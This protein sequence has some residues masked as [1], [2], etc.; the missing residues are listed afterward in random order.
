MRRSTI[1]VEKELY[2]GKMVLTRGFLILMH[3]GSGFL[4]THK[5]TDELEKLRELL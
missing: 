5:E 1:E 4:R 2:K 3:K